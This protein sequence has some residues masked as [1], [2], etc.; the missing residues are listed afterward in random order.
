MHVGLEEHPAALQRQV[1][2]FAVDGGRGVVHED[3][4]RSTELL[5]RLGHDPGP[6][7]LVGQVGDDDADLSAVGAQPISGT[8]E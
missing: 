4:D 6:I 3:V 2:E 7:G 5:G 1:G 8:C